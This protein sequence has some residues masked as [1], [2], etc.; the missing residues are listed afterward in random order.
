MNLRKTLYHG[1]STREY[2]S[3][4]DHR[5]AVIPDFNFFPSKYHLLVCCWGVNRESYYLVLGFFQESS[6]EE[7]GSKGIT[8]HT[9]KRL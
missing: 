6:T 3:H 8:T 5:C 1:S 2:H 9:E 7:E 4:F